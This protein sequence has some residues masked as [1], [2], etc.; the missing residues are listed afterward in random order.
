MTDDSFELN[1]WIKVRD[2]LLSALARAN[3]KI[4]SHLSAVHDAKWLLAEEGCSCE[5]DHSQHDHDVE[6]D[7]CLACRVAAVLDRVRP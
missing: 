3:G 1:A 4:A 2:N 7:R 5:C 6:C